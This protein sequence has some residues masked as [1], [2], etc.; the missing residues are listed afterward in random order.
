MVTG[1][2]RGN[3]P[4]S[5]AGGGVH[6]NKNAKKTGY[7]MYGAQLKLLPGEKIELILEPM[8]QK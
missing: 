4:E 2:Q 8:D 5:G 6:G 7:V 3:R 1:P